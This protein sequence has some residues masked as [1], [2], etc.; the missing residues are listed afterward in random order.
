M[1]SW[2]AQKIAASAQPSMGACATGAAM[3][4]TL[5]QPCAVASVLAQSTPRATQRT[6]DPPSSFL[7]S[8]AAATSTITAVKFDA[9]ES[10]R[11]RPREREHQDGG[12]AV[13]PGGSTLATRAVSCAPDQPHHAAPTKVQK[14]MRL[15][16]ASSGRCPAVLHPVGLQVQGHVV[17]VQDRTMQRAVEASRFAGRCQGDS[18]SATDVRW[19]R[20]P[21]Y[22]RGGDQLVG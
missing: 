10:A 5:V 12:R 21:W 1:T 7:G 19:E 8:A 3:R 11:P 18:S 14:P 22:W 16:A 17:H 9:G 15:G 2:T 6:D 13:Y 20:Q 4:C